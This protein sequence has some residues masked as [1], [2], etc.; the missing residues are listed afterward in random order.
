M[1]TLTAL[2]F[3]TTLFAQTGA[4]CWLPD[5]SV[6]AKAVCADVPPSVK[7]SL[8]TFL[9]TQMVPPVPP[10]TDPTPRYAGIGDLFLSNASTVVEA[11]LERHPPP[12]IAADK[13]TA[14]T[15]LAAAETKKAALLDKTPKAEPK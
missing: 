11:I 15:A 3:T 6:P 1:K 14:A 4:L 2:L 9:A 10:A 13:A 7:A 8:T 5:K 12:A